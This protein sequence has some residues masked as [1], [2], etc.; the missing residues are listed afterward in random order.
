MVSQTHNTFKWP[1]KIKEILLPVGRPDLWEKQ[2]QI[3]QTNVHETVK[4][5]L[6]DQ[7][8][9]KWHEQLQISNKGKI[10]NSFIVIH[11]FESYLKTLPKQEYLP[12]L[13]FRT[14]N[15]RLPVETGRYD[16][17]PLEGRECPLCDSDQVGSEKHYLFD[18][19]FFHTIRSSMK[20]RDPGL[21]A[22]PSQ[23]SPISHVFWGVKRNKRDHKNFF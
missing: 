15:H 22:T 19:S 14:A 17:T 7:Y 13:K 4:R 16:G 9:Q 8:K 12:L 11:E 10:Y 18:C 1:N 3:Q 6:I 5:I 2:F 23:M 21:F 20:M